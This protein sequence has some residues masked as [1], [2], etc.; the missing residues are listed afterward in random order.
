MTEPQELSQLASEQK[1][2]MDRAGATFLLGLR[3]ISH[4]DLLRAEAQA[5][6]DFAAAIIAMDEV[7]DRIAAGEKIHS[8]NEQ[9]AVER[10]KDAYAQALANLVRGETAENEPRIH[11]P[12]EV[13][14]VTA[15]EH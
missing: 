4:K 14:V 15:K 8:L 7:D 5:R 10:A 12:D 3:R 9:A 13:L 6:L 1:R 2:E 11:E